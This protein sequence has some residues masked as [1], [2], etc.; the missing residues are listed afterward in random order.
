MSILR[1]DTATEGATLVAT[2]EWQLTDIPVVGPNLGI[3]GLTFIP[4]AH[5]VAAG[6]R[7][8]TGARYDP[9][10][11][12]DH[13]TGLFFV[14]VEGNG[15][16]YGYALNHV[17]QTF[18]RITSFDGGGGVVKALSFDRDLGYL[19][20]YLGVA[21]ANAVNVFA[22]DRAPAS[23]TKGKF[24]SLSKY[25]APTG[26]P[27]INNEGI[28][29]APESQCVDG[30]KVFLWTD[31]TVSL[32]HAL[33]A[34]TI[35]CGR[36]IDDSDRD[37]IIDALDNCPSA[38]NPDQRD[39][40]GDGLGDL[41]DPDRDG[42]GV[43]DQT[44][45]CPM[46]A[47]ADQTDFDGDGLGDACD[48]DDDGDGVSDGIDSCSGTS[49]NALVN[50]SGCSIDDLAPCSGSWKNH[51]AYLVAYTLVVIRFHEQRLLSW[52][53]AAKLIARAA[54]SSCGKKPGRS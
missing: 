24:I 16:V 19:W 39:L 3:E 48:G 44:D 33:R 8:Q 42:D 41:C 51:G 35:P 26:M 17:T 28:A 52:Q 37:G 32:G 38:P 7:D 29:I 45:N 20:V 31:D 11:Y 53:E 50:A 30:F 13:G 54:L 10:G 49:A 34:G 23:A 18:T 36:F 12:P 22:I 21:N 25:A 4:D 1:F 2:H 5:L 9:T 27:A 47:N 6:L 15:M 43:L 46:V 14:G 40:D